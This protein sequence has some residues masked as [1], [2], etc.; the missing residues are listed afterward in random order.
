MTLTERPEEF[1]RM[2]VA[3]DRIHDN[4]FSILGTRGKPIEAFAWVREISE[5]EYAIYDK[6]A[7]SILTPGLF[8]YEVH[9]RWISMFDFSFKDGLYRV[10]TREE[11][12]TLQNNGIDGLVR[13]A[14]SDVST[15]MGAASETILAWLAE[16][17]REQDK[18]VVKEEGARM[19]I[20]P[21]DL[22][23]D[24]GLVIDHGDH[25]K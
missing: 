9:A 21:D 7:Q 17:R 3:V 19:E 8:V 12:L 22:S 14:W 10:L 24:I 25:E 23:L 18:I 13:D 4:N 6:E 15:F 5:V 16:Y 2:L 1:C 20:V 11:W